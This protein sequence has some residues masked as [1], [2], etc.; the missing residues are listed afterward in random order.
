M[1]KTASIILVLA[2][3]CG[4]LTGCGAPAAEPAGVSVQETREFTDDTGRTLTIPREVERIAVTGPLSQI[5]VI[6]IGGDL[7]VGCSNDFS[8]NAR[9]YLSPQLLALPPL[10]QLYGGRGTMDLEALLA[11]DPDLVIDMGEPKSGIGEELDALYSQCGIPFVHIDVTVE[12]AP[13]AY[14]RLG[15]LLGREERAEEIA[16]CLEGILET[17]SGIMEKVDAAGARKT[18]IYCLGDKGQN[19]LAA[20]SFHAETMELVADNAAVLENVV[21]S[22]GGNEVDMEQLMLWNP[23]V[24][25]FAPNSVFDSV[26]GDPAWQQL[27][28]V[29]NGRVYKTPAG[30]YGWLESPPAV[31]RYLGLMWLCV[32]LYPEYSTFD[33]QTSVEQYYELFYGYELSDADFRELTG[34]QA[35]RP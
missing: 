35:R 21:A 26:S 33:L 3:I 18:M 32:I 6:S 17:A 8:E 30:P 27:D 1:K 13:E 19:V 34:R 11:A 29:R 20:G 9:K 31:Q 15:E 2:V 5:Y 24:I 14:R 10:G 7:M 12:T 25:I 28:A 22:G 16:C 4:L 23:D